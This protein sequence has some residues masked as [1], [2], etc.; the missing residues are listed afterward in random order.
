MSKAPT[1][2]PGFDDIAMGGLPSGRTTLLTGGPGSGK[3]VFALQMLVH[4]A[5][6]RGEP[7]I[8]VAFEQAPETLR[9]DAANFD[10]AAGALSDDTLTFIDARPNLDMVRVGSFD[11]GGMLALLQ[12]KIRSTGAKIIVF[13]GIDVLLAQMGYA[14]VIRR[15]LYRLQD[16]LTQQGLT[17][18]ITCKSTISDPRFVSLPSLEFL[19]YMVDCSVLLNNDIVDDVSQRN[20]RIS[21]FRGSG[22]HGNAVPFL[23]GSGGIEVTLLHAALP[24]YRANT[25]ERLSSGLAA[26]DEMLLGGYFREACVL[27]TGLPGTGKTTLCGAFAA[28]ACAR[29][30]KTV[31]VSFVSR[32]EEIIHNLRSVSIDLE[33]FVLSGLLVFVSA[34]ASIGSG[35]THLRTI[36]SI[37]QDHD[38]ACIVIDPLTALTSFV[39]RRTTSGVTERLIDWAKAEGRTLVCTGL[40]DSPEELLEAPLFHISTIADTW[41]HLNNAVHG[42]QRKRNLSILKS[43]GTGHSNQVHEFALSDAGPVFE[44]SPV[45]G[46]MS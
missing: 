20:L 40:L 15:E 16:W 6:T 44:G 26:V 19:Q 7:G 21:K 37:A 10:W 28:A 46:G 34:R 11:V 41:I 13:D 45:N 23:I 9:T 18:L 39:T 24:T 36:R 14:E 2:I 3:T 27:L 8:F 42:H 38:A 17:A 43:R 4:G 25:S 35:E 32:Q 31:F 1:G 33:P 22:F 5:Q 12:A 29:G 30:E